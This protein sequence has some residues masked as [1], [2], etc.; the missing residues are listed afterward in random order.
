MT[1]TL[2]L[3]VVAA[4]FALLAIVVGVAAAVVGWA[5]EGDAW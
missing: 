1:I 5:T 2:A 3:T 4:A